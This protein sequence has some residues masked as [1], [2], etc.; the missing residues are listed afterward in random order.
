MQLP[1]VKSR[2]ASQSVR[3]TASQTAFCA[4]SFLDERLYVRQALPTVAS[5]GGLGTAARLA[6]SLATVNMRR[7][8]IILPQPLPFGPAPMEIALPSD[9]WITANRFGLPD[10][11]EARKRRLALACGF[12]VCYS[13]LAN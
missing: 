3:G 9:I 4:V 1:A 6:S 11:A 12:L 5:C 7:Y 2:Q 10:A 8:P 13:T